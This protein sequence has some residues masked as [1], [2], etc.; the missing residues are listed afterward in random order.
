M[1]K[2]EV[3]FYYRATVHVEAQDAEEALEKAR[4]MHLEV[5]AV[6]ND[7]SDADAQLVECMDPDIA[8]IEEE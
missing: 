3:G 1:A 5:S 2:F 8:E 6:S 4:D 7:D